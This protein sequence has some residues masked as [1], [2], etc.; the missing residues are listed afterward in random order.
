MDG[1]SFATFRAPRNNNNIQ[2]NLNERTKNIS[3]VYICDISGN[4]ILTTDNFSDI[5]SQTLSSG[6][7]VVKTIYTDGTTKVD[8]IIK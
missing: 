3:T 4:V 1:G 7:Y 5:Q 8:K 2:N 6:V